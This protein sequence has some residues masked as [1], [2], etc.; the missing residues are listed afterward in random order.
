MV[1]PISLISFTSNYECANGDTLPLHLETPSQCI[2]RH[3]PSA[4][5]DIT[6]V[7]LESPS[8][9]STGISGHEVNGNIFLLHRSDWRF[10]KHIEYP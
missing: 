2:W 4:F 8:L 3:S 5:G 1:R 10:F 7:H 6:P 9:C